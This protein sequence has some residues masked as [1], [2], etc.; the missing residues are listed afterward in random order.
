MDFDLS[1]F[2]DLDSM[3]DTESFDL[4]SIL[5]TDG[6]VLEDMLDGDLVNDDLGASFLDELSDLLDTDLELEPSDFTG[7]LADT[8]SSLFPD[9]DDWYCDLHG[10]PFTDA[11]A[12]DLQSTGYT[13]GIMSAKMVLALNGLDISETDLAC[14][15]TEAGLLTPGLGDD[16]GM[17][18]D[19]ISDLLE[20][21]GLENRIAYPSFDEIL[22]SLDTGK[23]I[24]LSVDSGEVW[25]HEGP[26]HDSID[27][28]QPDHV[29]V[30]TGIDSSSGT[31][32]L[33]DP[34]IENG[35]AFELPLEQLADAW[36]D[37]YGECIIVDGPIV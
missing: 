33:N 23:Q 3:L 10:E 14:Q 15:A 2:D 11:K 24:I 32:F 22:N 25:G 13:C 19:S 6:S 29:V 35:A 34:G 20:G 18:M 21:F 9:F 30:L 7:G 27:G 17:T 5:D 37:S 31:A 1:I 4:D 28:L 26:I 36:A 8:G 12:W 16:A